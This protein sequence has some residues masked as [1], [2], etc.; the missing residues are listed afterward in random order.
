MER[1]AASAPDLAK[2]SQELAGFWP[3]PATFSPNLAKISQELATFSSDLAKISQEPEGFSLGKIFL[4]SSWIFAGVGTTFSRACSSPVGNYFPRFCKTFTRVGQTFT[5]VGLTF[6]RV[7]KT[8]WVGKTFRWAYNI[9]PKSWPNFLMGVV[10][11]PELP[12][13]SQEL[14]KLSEGLVTFSVEYR[15]VW[16]E[17]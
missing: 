16:L 2:V 15:P 8:F 4:R 13:I 12:K 14:A 6:S 5:W 1:L 9:L 10:V 3:E 17:L 11:S 7:G